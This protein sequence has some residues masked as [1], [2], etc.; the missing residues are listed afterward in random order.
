MCC[1]APLLFQA[2]GKLVCIMFSPGPLR[3]LELL[4]SS[5]PSR[6]PFHNGAT[7][8]KILAWQGAEGNGGWETAWKNVGAKEHKQSSLFGPGMISFV[9]LLASCQQVDFSE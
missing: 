9:V 3:L 6:T 4:Q 7:A 8:V 2:N 1:S 5:S